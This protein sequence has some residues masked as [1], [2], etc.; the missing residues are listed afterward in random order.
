[1]SARRATLRIARR[2]ARRSKG[3][4]ALVVVMIA[5]PILG[6]GMADVLY[7][8][9]Q[10]THDQEATRSMGQADG[11]LNDTG[12]RSVIQVPG[13]NGFSSSSEDQRVGAAPAPESFLPAGSRVL[14]TYFDAPTFS[15]GDVSVQAS[16]RD[17]PWTDPLTKGIYRTASGR[18]AATPTEVVLTTYLANRLGVGIGDTVT[19][20]AEGLT[21]VGTVESTSS[22]KAADALLAPGSLP[23]NSVDTTFVDVPGTL[24]WA[25]VERANAVGFLFQPRAKTIP[26]QPAV[27]KQLLALSGQALTLSGLIAGLVLLEIVLLAGPA[28]AVGVK[29]RSRDLALVAATGG[30]GKHLRSVVLGG[31]VVLGV[32]GGTVGAVLG[33]GTAWALVPVLTELQGTRP[34]PFEVRPLEVL[35]VIAVGVLTA[36]LAS[37]I[38]SRQAANTDVLAALTGRRGAVRSTKRVPVLGAVAT[39]AGAALALYGAKKLN[40]NLVLAGSIGAELGLVATT[41]FLVGQVAKVGRFLPVAPRFA[42]RD[43]ARNRTRTAPAVSAILAAVAGAIAVG[44]FVG[45]LDAHDRQQYQQRGSLGTTTVNLSYTDNPRAE[46]VVAALQRT[47]PG[48]TVT[49]VDGV[50][51]AN[52]S[53]TQPP[54][55][56]SAQDNLG[57]RCP[58][59]GHLSPAAAKLLAGDR[60]CHYSTRA[61]SDL[62]GPLVGEPGALTAATGAAGPSYE[63]V[64]A[65]GGAVVP[66]GAVQDDGTAVLTVTPADSQK[67]SKRV[68][69]PAA[70]LPEDAVQTLFL[71]RQ[72]AAKLGQPVSAVGVLAH[73]KHAPSE[74]EE[75]LARSAVM[76]LGAGDLFVERGYKSNYGAGLLALLIGSTVIVLGASGIATGLAAADGRADL[77]TLSAVGATPSTRRTLAAFQSAVTAGLGTV[78]GV[79]AGLVPGI[80]I[81]R[82]INAAQHVGPFQ[83]D[84]YPLVLPW[85]NALLTLLL[86]PVLAALAAA[87]LTRSRLPVV[88]RAV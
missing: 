16:A 14:R 68:R 84:S 49:P 86:V 83:P 65:R 57:R 20:G 17:L 69:V 19:R 28:F 66:W 44:T 13:A 7:R 50:G 27:P 63:Q 56:V 80:A 88:R 1:M 33:I 55:N 76:A 60:R 45:S 35:A 52:L 73:D 81:V 48:A 12:S 25:D 71:S 8:T 21:V 6:V 5:L 79:A 67:P 32:V 23:T 40:T 30:E 58:D 77:G 31:G 53:N 51:V 15:H 59:N 72:A 75:D 36:L 74:H 9:F 87:A 42:L 82:A 39:A 46:Q 41:P 43:A 24:T 2:D 54:P 78:L 64:L 70:A 3:G 61:Y 26:G 29:R 4:S 10:L 62:R 22:S 34:G 37:L 11:T 18:P 85:T 38:P 47:L